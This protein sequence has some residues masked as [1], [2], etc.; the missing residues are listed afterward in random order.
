MINEDHAADGRL[1]DVPSEITIA[2]PLTPSTTAPLTVIDRHRDGGHPPTPATP[3][4]IKRSGWV[5]EV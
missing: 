1:S 4:K 5:L 3:S 2:A